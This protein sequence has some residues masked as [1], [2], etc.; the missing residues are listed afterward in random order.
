MIVSGVRIVSSARA[1]WNAGRAAPTFIIPEHQ[2][3]AHPRYTVWFTLDD[4]E[5]T[6]SPRHKYHRARFLCCG[7]YAGWR[8]FWPMFPCHIPHNRLHCIA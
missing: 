8:D 6:R 4:S 3:P 7:R 5:D 2:R 1:L